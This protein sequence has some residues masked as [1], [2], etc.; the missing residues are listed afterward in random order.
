MFL[1]RSYSHHSLLSAVPQIPALV[2]DAKL[3]GYTSIALTDEDTGS[4][5][6]DF[7]D[8]C[9]K[10]GLGFCPGTTLRI[11][12]VFS[13]VDSSNNSFG[14]A[15]NCSKACILSQNN[16][17]YKSILK[18]ISKARTQSEDNQ[19]AIDLEDLHLD[20]NLFILICSDGELVANIIDSKIGN[21]NKILDKYL[22]QISKENIIIELLMPVFEMSGE[23]TKQRN[24]KIIDFC[25]TNSLRYIVSPA[26]RY[27][28]QDDNEVFRVVLGIR[29]GKRLDDVVL[30][31]NFD[32]PSVN[33]LKTI[34]DYCPEA[35]DT[36]FVESKL[37][38]V[39][40]TDYDKHANEAFFP[41]FDLPINQSAGL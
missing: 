39:I 12:N 38:T 40:K 6:I 18:L 1:A 28:N 30:S 36:Q 27:L 2:A 21:A 34:F 4:G 13:T 8:A 15:K 41:L 26:P 16:N 35:F 37:N 32:L 7:Y 17:G 19:Y 29:D 9:Q 10:E 25:K 20:Q 14:S 11:N 22:A 24:L 5:L 23:I 3:K 33:H 31:R